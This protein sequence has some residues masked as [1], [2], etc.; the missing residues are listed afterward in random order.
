MGDTPLETTPA[1]R[2]QAAKT[3]LPSHGSRRCPHSPPTPTPLV[4]VE[5]SSTL[6]YPE[7]G[8]RES[9]QTQR[10]RGWGEVLNALTASSVSADLE[11]GAEGPAGAPSLD[12]QTPVH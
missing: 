5:I 3:H 11:T 6:S 1:E 2:L 10:R 9:R 4:E 12:S 8:A 7:S